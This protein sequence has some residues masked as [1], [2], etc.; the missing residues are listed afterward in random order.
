VIVGNKID[1]R[2]ENGDDTG[3]EHVSHEEG[4]QFAEEL[5]KRFSTKK[6]L[7]PVAFIETSCLRGDNIESVFK[8]AADLF[9]NGLQK[10][11]MQ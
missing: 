3:E 9:E 5:A 10:Q 1:L 2:T 11:M 4:F 6:E 8:T 7:H